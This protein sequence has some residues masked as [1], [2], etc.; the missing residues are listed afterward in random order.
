[1]VYED[2]T[3]LHAGER[4]VPAVS[5]RAHVLVVADAGKHEVGLARRLARGGGAPAA[6]FLHPLC[7]LP[8]RAVKDRDLVAALFEQVPRHRVAH[9]AQPDECD[10]CHTRA[11]HFEKKAIC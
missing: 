3:P 11:S 2:R 6:V 9:D 8:G 7:G 10:S 5:D 4:A 1:M